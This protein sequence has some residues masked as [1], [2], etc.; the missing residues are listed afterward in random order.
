MGIQHTVPG[1][2]LMD[3]EEQEGRTE[4]KEGGRPGEQ[5][6]EPRRTLLPAPHWPPPTD[7]PHLEAP[8]GKAPQVQTGKQPETA[9]RTT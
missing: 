6:G 5:S 7:P 4:G 3:E 2:G 8:P 9:R 1:E